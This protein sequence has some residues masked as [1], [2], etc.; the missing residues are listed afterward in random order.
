MSGGHTMD[1]VAGR[2]IKGYELRNRIGA[3]GFGAVYS[4]YQ[5][6]VDREV[7]IKIILPDYA[8]QP[9]FIRRFEAE[10]QLVARLEHPHIVPL[11]DY[12]REPDGAYLVMR[13]LDES[14]YDQLQISPLDPVR[15]GK[16]VEQIASALALAHRSGVVHRDLK[17]ANILL[18]AD[19]NGY[20][21]DFG[22]AKAIGRGASEENVSG[23]LGYISPEQL[24]NE[25]ST[26]AI[27]IYSFGVVLYETLTGHHPF[28]GDTPSQLVMRHLN[29]PLPA[30]K[31]LRPDLPANLNDIIQQATAKRA[32]DRY[33]NVLDIAA[34]LRRTLVE[35]ALVTAPE[36]AVLRGRL[37]DQDTVI[38]V[39]DLRIENPYKGLRPFQE[40]DAADFFGRDALIERL[41]SRLAESGEYQRFLAVVGP[42]GSGKSSAVRAGLVPALRK[43][44]INGS[45]NWFIVDMLPGAHPIRQLEAALLSVAVKP[46][47]HLHD[48]LMA[49]AGGLVWAVERVLAGV[50]NDLLLIIDQF[51]EVFT[52]LADERERLHFLGLLYEAI[53]APD[54][55]L[56]V[57]ITLRA[58]FTDRPLEYVEFGELLRHRT[59]FVLPLSAGEIERAITGPAERVG[60]GVDSDLIAAVVADVREEPGALP[61]LQY[62]LTEVFERRDNR[63]LSLAAYQASGGVLGALARRAQE[64]YDDLEVAQKHAARQIFLR[65]VTLGEGTEDTRRRAIRSELASV[66]P[67]AGLLQSVLNAFGQFR[68]LAFDSELTT[69]EP[70]VEVA[71][72]ALL[73]EWGQLRDWLD[74]GRADVRL[75]RMLAAA[76]AEWLGAH[77]DSSYLLRGARLAQFE[78]WA[79]AT[80]IALT[81]TERAYIEA[82]IA[83]R[84]RLEE[85]ER[86][87]QAHEIE[88]ERRARNRMR[89]LAVVLL[90]ATVGAVLLS[91]LA[92]GQSQV[93]QSAQFTSDANAQIAIN[94]AAT[95]TYALGLSGQ[96]GTQA[97]NQASTAAANAELAANNAATAEANAQVALENAATA[98][99]AQ[100]DALFQAGTAVAAQA[101][102]GANAVLA[103]D[104]AATAEANAQV[105][106]NNAAT[107]TIAQGDALIQ[108]GTAVAAQATSVANADL[109]ATNAAEAE[110]NAGVALNNAATATVAQGDALV[111]AETAVAAQSTSDA[112]AALAATNAAEAEANAR[113]A[114][115][116]A[117]TATIA[118]GDALVQAEA[119][120]AAQMT[121]D[122]NADLAA[123]NAATAEANAQVALNNAATATVAQGDA[124]VQAET[125][126]A[127][128]STSGANAALAATNA[129]VADANADRALASEGTAVAALDIS[130]QSERLARAQAL[131]SYADQLLALGNVD[132]ALTLALEAA[133]LNP[134]LIQAQRV[135]S[136]A[137]NVSPLLSVPDST[138]ALFSPDGRFLLTVNNDEH[139]LYLW[140]IA[141]RT[142]VHRMHGHLD[143]ITAVAFSLDGRFVVSGS[144]DMSLVVWDVETGQERHRL[145]GHDEPVT[146]LAMHP[147]GQWVLSSS[148]TAE[149]TLENDPLDR[150]GKIPLILW[151]LETGA[152]VQQYTQTNRG[153]TDIWVFSPDG[154]T[155]ITGR[156]RW[157]TTA[158]TL[159]YSMNNAFRGF[160]R[161]GRVAW[162]GGEVPDGSSGRDKGTAILWNAV[163]EAELR[164]LINGFNWTTDD[165][166]FIDFSPDG[167]TLLA[168]VFRYDADGIAMVMQSYANA[169]SNVGLEDIDSERQLV[170]FDI[171]SGMVLNRY[172]NND[173]AHVS[174]ALFASDNV[175]VLSTTLDNRLVL[176][177]APTG[178]PIR[179]LGVSDQ[180][181][182]NLGFNAD[183][184]YALSLAADGTAYVW[185]VSERQTAEELRI[186]VTGT[187]G[188]V[189]FSP[190]E[191][192]IYASLETEMVVFDR[193][194][195]EGLS[196]TYTGNRIND[197]AF[198]PQEPRAMVSV[199]IRVPSSGHVGGVTDKWGQVLH[200]DMPT[201]TVLRTYGDA[202]ARLCT[203]A[204][205][206]DGQY[207]LL[208]GQLWTL[209]T[210]PQMRL[211]DPDIIDRARAGI[212]LDPNVN[213]NCSDAESHSSFI[214]YVTQSISPDNQYAALALVYAVGWQLREETAPGSGQ[215]ILLMEDSIA[216]SSLHLMAVETGEELRVLAD[217]ISS[218]TRLQFSPDSRT[219]LVALGSPENSLILYDVE[220]GEVLRRFI[221][222]ND[223][224]NDAVFSP[225]GLTMLSASDD[226]SLILWNVATG[227]PILNY[228]GHDDP[229]QRVAFNQDGRAAVSTDGNEIIVWRVETLEELVQWTRANR[230]VQPLSCIQRAQYNVRPLCEELT[231]TP[232]PAQWPSPTL[233]PTS[234]LRGEVIVEA[235]NVRAARNANASVLTALP[236]GTVVDII[237]IM[238]EW[239]QIILPDGRQGWI[240]RELLGRD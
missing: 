48:M 190:D 135:L 70:T 134:E 115:N 222:H 173:L 189:G 187:V 42:S 11:F 136:Q 192:Q 37:D 238:P 164:R 80:D 40:A 68:L 206:P 232:T 87:R 208:E 165:L 183:E 92:F 60:L 24:R 110:A 178:Q 8:N 14:L 76:A 63:S 181:L 119:A 185:D 94:N 126:V 89:S 112:N 219:L 128:Q 228:T 62:A 236:R 52:L 18:D 56:R 16:L 172:E 149:R 202:E 233:T 102:S 114:L 207:A 132:L 84:N 91:A 51:E 54:S 17:P 154:R 27:D 124:L 234:F 188:N 35:A 29:D 194:S 168:G 118:Q 226:G 157:N 36:T 101:T 20:L 45:S 97:A 184:T 30:L 193:A 170:Y 239:Y 25:P 204:Y 13:L 50:K 49:S 220:T 167:R 217:F 205:S 120:M 179:V 155:F 209:E 95:A 105:A 215:Y 240:A 169:V 199:A 175:T 214:D 122:A 74:H 145:I 19:G 191:Q 171:A 61:L 230:D 218:P 93:A 159:A 174:S 225:D 106:L 177:D 229:V 198:H 82:S 180:P 5:A 235:A 90:I 22:I 41:V 55:R 200:W 141:G 75:Q 26:P 64:V 221:G 12:W 160:S 83:H 143:E 43:D 153:V 71:H 203:V 99:I 224:V 142:L 197:V 148:N 86:E 130:E 104:N 156:L 72:E 123:D 109:A 28:A 32:S 9:D 88:L 166:S 117:A 151:D 103:A 39:A 140:D 59:E 161:D 133:D 210:R 131:A 98:T 186:D 125:A 38:S 211:L 108:A 65:L 66:I 144:T 15:A 152:Q 216:G 121:S 107:A 7:A 150:T 116:N 129:A 23:S 44:A 195:G 137:A 53:I 46:P 196:R 231:P 6:V 78:E 77:E 31:E 100:G 10:A 111:Q 96:R 139:A 57:M 162:T 176:W 47:S 212:A 58:D 67:D 138:D 81:D 113:I 3:G 85:E 73:R 127:A 4:A 182:T 33:T 237:R 147:E 223:A 227:Q 201:G 69:R 21:S 79:A 146:D 34:D 2:H 158:G 213:W 1:N 163:T